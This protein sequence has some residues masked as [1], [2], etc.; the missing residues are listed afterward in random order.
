IPHRLA[1]LINTDKRTLA[2]LLIKLCRTHVTRPT[3]APAQ[4]PNLIVEAS[5]IHKTARALKPDLQAPLI[6]RMH[7][8]GQVIPAQLKTAGKSLEELAL[9]G[10]RL[11]HLQYKTQAP[12]ILIGQLNYPALNH[13]ILTFE[14]FRQ[15]GRQSAV[16]INHS[17]GKTT[18]EAT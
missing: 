18:P 10:V 13:Q 9:G 14:G 6:A 8:A 5:R 11:R 16:A 4:L 7:I 17:P 3:H 2:Q 12:A 15:Q 1:T